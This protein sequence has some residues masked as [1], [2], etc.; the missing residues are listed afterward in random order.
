MEVRRDVHQ[1]QSFHN[2]DTK[3]YNR[4]STESGVSLLGGGEMGGVGVVNFSLKLYPRTRKINY[5]I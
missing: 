1:R 3:Q 2:H 5:I 4:K